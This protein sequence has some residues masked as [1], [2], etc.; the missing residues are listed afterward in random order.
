MQLH[1]VKK[2]LWSV[3]FQILLLFSGSFLYALVL[4]RCW[5][6]FLVPV[7]PTFI[8]ISYGQAYGLCVFFDTLFSLVYT[9]K[10]SS[11]EEADAQEQHPFVTPIIKT[12]SKVIVFLIIWAI[13]AIVAAIIGA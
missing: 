13:A 10:V 8:P 2:Q 7:A 6:W 1:N 12:V 11:T 4:S 3:L 5:N 9:T